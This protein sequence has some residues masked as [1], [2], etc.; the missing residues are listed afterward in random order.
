[1]YDRKLIQQI[2]VEILKDEKILQDT[3][4]SKPTLHVVTTE[5]CHEGLEGWKNDWNLKCMKPEEVDASE[6]ISHALFPHVEQDLFVKSAL[7]VTD[8]AESRC[9]SELLSGGTRVHFLLDRSMNLLFTPSELTPAPYIER[10]RT[11]EDNLRSYRVSVLP[12]GDVLSPPGEASSSPF[13]FDGK[14]L[15]QKEMS[16][17]L[18]NDILISRETIVTPLAKDTAREENITISIEGS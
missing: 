6:T 7:G 16:K 2:V 5:G 12:S 18:Y 3:P 9:F 4:I 13:Y 15:T 11:Y 17:W 10:L 8:T 1:M 14:L